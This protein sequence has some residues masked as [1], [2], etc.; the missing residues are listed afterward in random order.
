MELL[1]D[2]YPFK[3]DN[4]KEG[5][6]NISHKHNKITISRYNYNTGINKRGIAVVVYNLQLRLLF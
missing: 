5:Y 4:I 6:Y 3:Q 2:Y 1:L